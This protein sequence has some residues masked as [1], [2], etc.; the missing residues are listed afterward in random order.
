M[1]FL[2]KLKKK[3]ETPEQPVDKIEAVSSIQA[4]T[5]V[6][7]LFDRANI[8]VEAF[9]KVVVENFGRES[10][11]QVDN[12]SPSI[13]HF[14]LRVD[15]IEMM[16]SYMPFP[17]PKEEADIPALLNFNGYISEEERNAFMNQQSFCMIAQIGGGTTLEGKRA[18]CMAVSRLCG[19][20]LTMDGAS[21]VYYSA[22]HLLIGK[23]AYL[24]HVAIME[25]QNGDPEY[26]PSMLWVLV[27]ASRADDGSP[28][29][30]TY[31]LE[32]FGFM[33]L[34][35][36]KP[37]EDWAQSY[38]K[39]YMMSILQITGAEFYKNMDTISFAE[40][41]LSIFKQSGK[42]LYVIGGI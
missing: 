40:G 31:G 14:M 30:E 17:L 1:G 21:G 22:A 12:S 41:E 19:A 7:M 39:L 27:C 3:K 33:E 24:K 42:K 6:S 9:E 15:G 36:Y 8:A 38:Q 34:V 25:Q 35:F 5:M 32:Q 2:D 18:V 29:I 20:L 37:T 28:T 23:A 26:F 16:C 4:N 13:T 11:L 10:L